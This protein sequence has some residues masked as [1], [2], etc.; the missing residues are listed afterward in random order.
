MKILY[1]LSQKPGFTGSGY[2]VRSLIREAAAAN[3]GV[4]LLSAMEKGESVPIP[5]LSP[6]NSRA[7]RFSSEELPF[8]IPGMSDVM[9]YP[10]VCFK[11]LTPDQ[12]D[13]YELVFKN[14]IRGAVEKFCPDIIHSNHLWLMSAFAAELF[15][16]IP[17]VI[18]C[19]GTDIR[20][21]DLCSHLGQR[22]VE[23]CRRA[24]GILALSRVQKEEISLLYGIPHSKIMVAGTGFNEKL[25]FPAQKPAPPPVNILYAGKLSFS[26]GVFW[27]L[28]A[29]EAMAVSPS[30]FHLFLA[31]SGSGTEYETCLRLAKSMEDRVSLTGMLS[32][33]ELAE[34]MKE[35]HI[36]ILPSFYE[37]LPLVLFEA[38]ASGCRVM[39]T[40]LPGTVEITGH[41]DSDSIRLLRLPPLETI[42]RPF[43]K[44]MPDMIVRLSRILAEE[45]G[46]LSEN[47][48]MDTG[49]AGKRMQAFTWKEVFRRIETF[50]AELSS[51]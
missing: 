24:H 36:F 46:R 23:G 38:L 4:F 27:L 18:S 21:L 16:E 26:K 49:E 22:V 47:L 7:I 42:D 19:H 9:P 28:K 33:E 20:Q 43:E 34:R 5:H 8:L 40:D 51:F 48:C 35:A 11:N 30:S 31:G 37:G 39:A 13:T 6:E 10:S 3:H 14:R 44:D 29:V 25:F 2:Y 41:G 15:P 12:L 32:Q 1:L 45:I 17:L 50:Y